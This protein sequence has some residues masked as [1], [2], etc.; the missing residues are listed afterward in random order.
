MMNM[1]HDA[2]SGEAIHYLRE[3]RLRRSHQQAGPSASPTT[4]SWTDLVSDHKTPASS[5]SSHRLST[6]DGLRYDEGIWCAGVYN[7]TRGRLSDVY[8]LVAKVMH[9]RHPVRW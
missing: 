9:S 8:Q 3:C 6:E 1:A 7:S 4:V 2:L 5:L